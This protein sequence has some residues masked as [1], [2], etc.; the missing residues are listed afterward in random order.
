MK[1]FGMMAFVFLAFSAAEAAPSASCQQLTTALDKKSA[2]D[3]RVVFGYKDAR[4]ARFV[5][6]RHERVAFI[7][8]LTSPCK[9]TDLAC[10]F[11]RMHNN[12]DLFT[13]A[14]GPFFNQQDVRVTV[15][16]SSVGSDDAENLNDPFQKWK[17]AQAQKEFLNGLKE[18]DIVLYNGH[19][20]F[21]GG[22]DFVSPELKKDGSVKSAGYKSNRQGLNR[23]LTALEE[24]R[25]PKAAKFSGLKVIGMYSCSSSQL[26]NKK[27]RRV[28]EAGLIS[29]DVLMYYSDALTDSLSD[30]SALLNKRCP[31]ALSF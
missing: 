13:R 10:G 4:P 27:I 24:S 8:K 14:I 2:I 3:V 29:S 17:S 26:F 6:D 31:Q 18:A 7:E 28:S 16:N 19:S 5:G 11:R 12:A 21:G 20:R 23:M 9:G 30:L 1:L 15:V 25:R 22:P